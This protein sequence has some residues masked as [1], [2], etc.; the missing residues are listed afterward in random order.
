M[1]EKNTNPSCCVESSGPGFCSMPDISNKA[2]MID[3][4]SNVQV[5]Q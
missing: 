4:R 3:L 1:L 2:M 5:V